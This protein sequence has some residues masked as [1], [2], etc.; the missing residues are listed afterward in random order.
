MLNLSC[1]NHPCRL[2]PIRH[3]G[4]LRKQ[5]CV[6]NRSRGHCRFRSPRRKRSLGLSPVEEAN[7]LEH[8][9]PK[10][11]HSTPSL[12]TLNQ[13]GAQG[14]EATDH[15]VLPARTRG[16][17]RLRLHRLLQKFTPFLRLHRLLQRCSLCR[18]VARTDL[19]LV[20]PRLLSLGNNNRR[21][22]QKQPLKSQ[23]L[24]R[25]HPL[26][27]RHQCN[28]LTKEVPQ[29]PSGRRRRDLDRMEKVV[30]QRHLQ[31]PRGHRRQHHQCPTYDVN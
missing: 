31:C 28:Q 15:L 6:C 12:G 29:Y 17:Q 23:V 20:C 16:R 26:H 4:Q 11:I 7:G 19:L 2:G 1:T 25:P 10:E 14:R 8:P 22:K 13:Y 24:P 5:C 30:C 3:L 9:Y 18:G 27:P 21:P